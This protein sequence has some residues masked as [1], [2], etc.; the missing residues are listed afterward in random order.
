VTMEFSW[1]VE[2]YGRVCGN[3]VEKRAIKI[4]E[5]EVVLFVP[6]S[7]SAASFVLEKKD[8]GSGP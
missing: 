7:R 8:T 6:D 1:I 4:P 5:P 3:V 2:N